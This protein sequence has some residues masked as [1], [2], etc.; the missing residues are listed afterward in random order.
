MTHARLNLLALR[1]DRVP[2]LDPDGAP[3]PSNQ[4]PAPPAAD[5]P[6]APA[7]LPTAATA[8]QAADL[9]AVPISRR[10]LIGL[11]AGA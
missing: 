7:P 5:I 6:V 2:W 4:A 8:L 3:R 11:A 9:A 10:R 1:A